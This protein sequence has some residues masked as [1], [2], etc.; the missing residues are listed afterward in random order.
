MMMM[1]WRS[2]IRMKR[3]MRKRTRREKTIHP[4]RASKIH[5]LV[6]IDRR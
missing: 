2:R 4:S 5:W 3:R 1:R 6:M